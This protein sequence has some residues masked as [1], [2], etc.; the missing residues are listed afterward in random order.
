MYA[1]LW[2]INTVINLFIYVLIASAVLSW[3]VA[4]NVVNVRNPI[5]AQI[6]EVLYRL[7][8]PALRPIRNLLPNLGGVDISPVILILLLL[9]VQRLITVD[10][11]RF[12]V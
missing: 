2:L 1:L 10:L 8:E 4:F 12:L 5:V 11:A 3:L 7:T 6:G 9:F